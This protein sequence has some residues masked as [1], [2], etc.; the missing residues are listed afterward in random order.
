MVNLLAAAQSALSSPQNSKET[1]AEMGH[2]NL[3]ME[4]KKDGLLAQPQRRNTVV[5]ISILVPET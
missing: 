3:E 5:G 2:L 1:G 4:W